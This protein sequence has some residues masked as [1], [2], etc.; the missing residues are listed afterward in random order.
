MPVKIFF[1]YAHEDEP[2]LLKLKAHLRPLQ[3]QGFIDVWY[4]R[5]INAGTEWEQQIT[6][7]LNTSQIILLL[8]S[9]DFMNSDYCYGTEMKRALER[10]EQKEARVIPVILRPVYWQIRSLHKLQALPTDA[11]PIMSSSWQYQDEAFFNVAEGIRKIVEQM[12]SYQKQKS[13]TMDT[14][15]EPLTSYQAQENLKLN[16]ESGELVDQD[17]AR[18]SMRNSYEAALVRV[19]GIIRDLRDAKTPTC[20]ISYAWGVTVNE[21]WVLRLADDLQ[22]ADITVVLDQRDNKNIGANVARYVS[23]I[24]MS[25]FI[26]VVGTPAYLEK[27]KNKF[28]QYGSVVQAEVDLINVRMLGT[29]EQKASVLP[30]L[31]DGDANNSFPPL[32]CNRVYGDFRRDDYYFVTL[33]DLVL[34]IY[35]IKFDDPIVQDLR[36][37]LKDDAFRKSAKH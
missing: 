33:F 5:D 1:C 19:K 15:V 16:A 24:E 23:R 32:L 25:D 17:H 14:I 36:L 9:P 22:K 26:V 12:T 4:D 6:E 10:H 13:L 30:V 27:Y 18:S 11:K 29:T 7:E 28:P 31:L 8:V 34:T 3:R 2:L 20:F 37:T 35:H 21:K